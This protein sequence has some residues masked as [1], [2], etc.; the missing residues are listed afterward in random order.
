MIFTLRLPVTAWSSTPPTSTACS[1]FQFPVV[2]VS[3]DVSNVTTVSSPFV[4]VTVT[5]A[6]G[7]VAS[8]TRYHPV[9]ASFGNSIFVRSN[10]NPGLSVFV[11]VTDTSLASSPS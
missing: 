5:D 2:N 3:D 8:F 1:V 10:R 11:T 6:V 4:T 9:Q 7:L